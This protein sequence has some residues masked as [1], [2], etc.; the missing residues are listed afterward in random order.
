[1]IAAGVDGIRR[2]LDPGDP[3]EGNLFEDTRFPRLPTSPAESVDALVADGEL[4][5]ALG[6]EFTE[7]FAGLLRFD[8]QRFLSHVTDWEINEYREML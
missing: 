6:P 8:W 2:R 1:M 5:R 7:T 3:A 4:T